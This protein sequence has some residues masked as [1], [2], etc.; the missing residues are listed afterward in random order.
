VAHARYDLLFALF[1]D[2]EAALA[3]IGRALAR[4]DG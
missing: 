3:P 2:A 4:L 1:R